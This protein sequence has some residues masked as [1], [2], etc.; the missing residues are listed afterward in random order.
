[1]VT[2][3]PP[4][5]DGIASY[6]VQEVVALVGDGHEVEVL[7]PWPSAAHHHL[8]L[9]GPRGPLAL[10]KRVG[11]YDKVIIQYHPDVFYP[12][13]LTRSARLAVTAG[14]ALAFARKRNVEVR[15]HEINFA[16]GRARFPFGSLF[17][18][19]WRLPVAITVH[20]A[21]ERAEL[22]AA[23]GLPE[24]RVE[25]THHGRNFVPRVTIDKAEARRRLGIDSES[26][27]FLA[28]GFVQPHKGFDR[29]VRAF[30]DLG[31]YGCRLDIVGSVRVDEP[32]YV[33]Y[34]ETLEDLV[35]STRSAHLH[36]GYVSDEAFDTWLVAADV[37]LLP[38]RFIWSS[39]VLERAALFDTP[40][41]A[42]RV[43]GLD[44]QQRGRVRLVDDDAELAHAMREAAGI[45]AAPRRLDW[46]QLVNDDPERDVI[47][48][49][50]R[51][52]AGE[53]EG[54]VAREHLQPPAAPTT[55]LR[56]LPPLA[57]PSSAS[58]NPLARLVKRVVRRLTA[59]QID[60]IVHQVNAVQRATARSI[61]EIE[62]DDAS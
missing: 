38:Y 1:M 30:G 33:A 19:S 10:A 41:I 7:S 52:R 17:R 18:A 42:T 25:V 23:V 39:S 40:V 20:T 48:T 57:V 8:A 26:F 46:P 2:P 36:R 22:A 54:V 58:R 6:A 45:T 16:W 4:I 35:D 44:D 53:I 31:D 43:G 50:I 3:Y 56:G 12:A 21:H 14:L 34:A 59:W 27:T 61:D 9:R 5:R 15:V 13:P 28:I 32:E 49:A 11:R 55:A 24:D 62:H 47:L 51:S 37:L 60:P 29:A